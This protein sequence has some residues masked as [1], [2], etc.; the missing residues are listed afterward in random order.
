VSVLISSQ[1]CAAGLA[2]VSAIGF[3]LSYYSSNV[4]ERSFTAE[5]PRVWG[6]TERA[7]DE[8]AIPVV[9]KEL[10][11]GQGGIQATA[12]E[13]EITI[14]LKAV[15][16]MTTR[17]GV[18]AAKPNLLR[19][20]ATAT[21][22]LEQINAQLGKGQPGGTAQTSCGPAAG[23]TR[24]ASAT[25]GTSRTEAGVS[26]ERPVGVVQI[27]VA[28][29]DI[30]VAADRSSKVLAVLQRGTKLE[31]IAESPGWV[32]VRLPDGAEGFIAQGLVNGIEE[33]PPAGVK[34]KTVSLPLVPFE[35]YNGSQ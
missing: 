18:N 23:P 26:P 25:N 3:G 11:D 21:E 29:A 34:T 1:G 12:I 13:L 2:A 15:S 14:E 19:D 20:M 8:M 31:K 35:E 28:A 32:K 4:A 6:A 27:K 17:V 33:F 16:P 7:L 24:Q 22:I 5:L 30:R 9:E 10:G